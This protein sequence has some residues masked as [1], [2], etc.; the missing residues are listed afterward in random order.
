MYPFPGPNSVI[1]MDNARIHHNSELINIV[2]ELGG[3]VE[4]LP[5]YSPDL[6]PIERSFSVIKAWIKRHRRFMENFDDPIHALMLVCAQITSDDAIQFICNIIIIIII[7]K[8]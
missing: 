4:F 2:Q 7:N 5:P 1:I 6:N 8:V 3:K